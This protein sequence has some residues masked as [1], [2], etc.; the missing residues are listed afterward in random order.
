MSGDHCW[1]ILSYSGIPLS[2]L[3]L[4]SPRLASIYIRYET[5]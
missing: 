1:G 5:S 4:S 3:P 2:S